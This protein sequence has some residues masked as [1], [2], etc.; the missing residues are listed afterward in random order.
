MASLPATLLY[1]VIY[2]PSLKPTHKHL[3][4]SNDDDNED[5][6]EQAQ[7]LFYT[8]KDHAVSK[9]RVLRQVGLAKALVN[10][11]KLVIRAEKYAVLREI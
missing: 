4:S 5:A 11:S 7:V 3:D 2:N 1:F 9:D 6:E 10:F 8:A